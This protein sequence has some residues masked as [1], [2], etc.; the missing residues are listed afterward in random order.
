MA[1]SIGAAA[2]VV[3][4]AVLGTATATAATAA[5]DHPAAAA[6]A[7]PTA[8]RATSSAT[9]RVVVRRI[10]TG[11]SAKFTYTVANLSSGQSAQLQRTFGTARTWKR[12]VGLA[13]RRNASLTAPALGTLGA[14][15]YR[16]AI[17]RAGKLVKST[18]PLMVYVYG[19]VPLT[20]FSNGGGTEQVGSTLFS[21]TDSQYAY[22]YP[23]YD[24]NQVFT[25]TSCR[26]L[27][28]R[29]A[30]NDYAQSNGEIA[31]L[32]FV[33]SSSDPAYNQTA[34]GVIGSV[35]VALDGGPLYIDTATSEGDTINFNITGSCYTVSGTR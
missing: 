30:G 15:A 26:S 9:L 29:Y 14:Y 16:I 12:V 5:V 25:A 35:T 31:Y 6:S 2:I 21:Y 33:Q 4:A 11:G 24:Q 28:V 1:R 19:N 22:D 32:D 17:V 20:P 3:L 7:S 23:S 10:S 27:T 34:A 13:A 8:A 18:G